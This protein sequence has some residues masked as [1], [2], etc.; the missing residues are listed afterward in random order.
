MGII[1][2]LAALSIAFV[3]GLGIVLLRRPNASQAGIC[4]VCG[5]ALILGAGLVSL[6]SF[7]LG[8]LIHGVPLRC[9]VIGVCLG[10]AGY[11][12][13][14]RGWPV[15]A[16]PGL[17]FGAPQA[18]LIALVTAQVGFVTWLSLY[19]ESLGWDGLFNWES[20]ARAAFLNGGAIPL[21]YYSSNYDF[22]HRGY[23]PLVPLLEAWIYGFL[24][25]T[26]QSMIKLIGPYFYLAATLLVV[27]VANQNRQWR[28]SRIFVILPF[29]LVPALAIGQG[30]ASSGYADFPLSAV[31]LCA[32]I[33]CLEY[34]RTR[35]MAPARLLGLTA[36]LLPFTKTEGIVPLFCLAVAIIPL[37]VKE[38]NWK[39]AVWA[40]LPGLGIWLGWWTFLRSL[41]V[42]R[43]ADFAGFTPA[44]L[45]SHINRAGPLLV[46]TVE[47]L[48]A[49]RRWS[50][51]WPLV[52]AGLF[53]LVRRQNKR[54]PWYPWAAA[55]CLPLLLY[56][57]VYFFSA[58]NPVETHVR[59]S[60]PRLFVQAASV[61]ALMVGVVL[62]E[63]MAPATAGTA[64]NSSRRDR[65]S[66]VPPR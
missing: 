43:E 55:V 47:E 24:G 2:S 56:P 37:A 50:L 42:P 51:L 33:Y 23:P 36:A 25:R 61:A 48:T 15:L 14:R 22:F 11:A 58:W 46:W 3:G 31:Y 66:Q 44:V 29:L 41:G 57:C 45:L 40:I 26:D 5:S 12:W 34:W 54:L 30:S 4:G 28:W 65:R 35:S 20:K 39:S 19:R 13:N 18:I 8:L 60:L 7:Y 1:L 6:S 62:A 9:A 17:R 52:A 64:D 21:Q 38:R 16:F 27:S 10:M 53:Y 59:V 32:A 63:V 49:L